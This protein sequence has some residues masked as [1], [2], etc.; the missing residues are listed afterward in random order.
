MLS[1]LCLF[2]FFLVSTA[3]AL[4]LLPTGLKH[5][6]ATS[7]V[8]LALLGPSV[9]PAVLAADVNPSQLRAV[10]QIL[11]VQKSLK[12]IDESIEKEGS[13]AGV[14]QQINLLLKNYKLKENLQTSLPL[15]AGGDKRREEARIHGQT[16]IEDLVI[17]SEYYDDD[18]DDFTGKK[19][20]PQKVLQLALQAS[21][22]CS[23]E[24]KELIAMYPTEVSQLAEKEVA[25]E[26]Q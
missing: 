12:Y 2:I 14:V 15:I 5:T 17:V 7:F 4:R 19:T 25:V 13:P 22:A 3:S 9:P 20:P 1:R 26:F 11:R 23:K 8:G 16:A 6:L 24:L 10:E 21:A 18:I